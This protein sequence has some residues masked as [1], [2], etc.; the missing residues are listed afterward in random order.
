M[1]RMIDADKLKAALLKA[2]AHWLS[3]EPVVS[4]DDVITLIDELPAVDAVPV[5]WIEKQMRKCDDN[6]DIEGAAAISWIIQT[7]K[8][9]RADAGELPARAD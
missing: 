3:L 9:E 1:S 4:V 6:D 7:W 2:N 8:K 5:E